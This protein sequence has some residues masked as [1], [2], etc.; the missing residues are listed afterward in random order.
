MMKRPVFWFLARLPLMILMSI[1]L[2]VMSNCTMLGLNYA[3]LEVD[4]K[5]AP[6]PTLDV[7]ALVSDQGAREALKAQ[8]EEVMY[9]PWPA[10]LPVS[11]G[12]W[13]TVDADYLDGRGTL[14]EIPVTMGVGEGARTFH[15][16]VATPHSDARVP[17][18]ISQ[19]FGSNCAAFPDQ[20]VTAPSGGVCDGTGYPAW[21]EFLGT[22]IFGTYIMLAPVERYFDA[23]FAYASFYASEFVP[24]RASEAPDVMAALGGPIAPTSALM[25]WAY[26]FSGVIDLLE[27]DGRFAPDF[28]AAM[29][30]SRH[31]K[32]AL[33]AGV[34]DRRI[35][36]VIAHQAGFAG[37]SLSRS[38]TGEGL[39]RMVENYPH[40]VAPEAQAY[41]D[42]LDELP[43]DQHQLLA[44]LAPTPVLLGN[45]RRDV[46][47]DPN[48][49]FRAAEAANPVYQAFGQ[50]GMSSSTMRDPHADDRLSWWL[51]P[52]GHSVV[53]EDIDQ[54]IAFAA[55]QANRVGPVVQT[56]QCAVES[57]ENNWEDGTRCP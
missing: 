17:I 37:A 53:S 9:G 2:L 41:L 4:N 56:A 47:S 5:P 23:G 34:W 44:L 40:W 36:A 52:G 13:R 16:V 18:I 6:Y 14:E 43:V 20:P 31:G 29:G 30:H 19:T 8:F 55:A 38:T 12:E 46:W 48:S 32:S 45:G 10:G 24:D 33:V 15:L 27:A 21:A 1:M 54:F 7:D 25:A 3:S 50:G 35:D 11:W 57:A 26:S 28:M 51:R 49:S 22:Q 42:R 39:K